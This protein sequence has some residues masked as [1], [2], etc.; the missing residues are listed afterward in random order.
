M[1][2]LIIKDPNNVISSNASSEW[3][4]NQVYEVLESN[5]KEFLELLK[6]LIGMKRY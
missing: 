5:P 3:L 2:F 4:F 6:M 1:E